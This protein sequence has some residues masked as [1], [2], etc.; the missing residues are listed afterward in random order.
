[1]PKNNIPLGK[2]RHYKGGEYEVIGVGKHSE[3]LEELVIYK[4]LENGEIWIR[5]SKMF[6]ENINKEGQIFP[7]FQFIKSIKIKC[8]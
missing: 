4:S 5:P 1:M 6:I 2:Y 7:R 8:R 3:T